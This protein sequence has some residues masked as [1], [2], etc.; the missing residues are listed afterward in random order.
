MSLL[1]ISLSSSELER[2]SY[3]T[4]SDLYNRYAAQ[5]EI[6]D[7]E[8]AY[9]AEIERVEESAFEAGKQ[10]GIVEAIG[11]ED[12][13]LIQTLRQEVE[14]LQKSSNLTRNSLEVVR[15]WLASDDCKT[16]KGRKEFDK[17]LRSCLSGIP[18]Y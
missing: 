4:G 10:A 7:M 1:D 13:N 17:R 14:Q 16:V 3:I 18:R 11:E 9:E 5:D 15:T 12:A 6:D 2:L 8:L